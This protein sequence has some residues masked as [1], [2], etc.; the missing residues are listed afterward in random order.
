MFLGQDRANGETRTVCFG[1]GFEIWIEEIHDRF[2]DLS[3]STGGSSI[4]LK[5][6]WF[7]EYSQEQQVFQTHGLIFDY[8][9]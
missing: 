6:F 2:P 8:A 3:I 7:A 1:T 9:A 4:P 5:D